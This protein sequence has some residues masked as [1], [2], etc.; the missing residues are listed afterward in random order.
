MQSYSSKGGAKMKNNLIQYKGGGYAGCYWEWNFGVF[1]RN[2]KYHDIYSS[3]KS[4]CPTERKIQR[5]IKEKEEDKDYYL[6]PLTNAKKLAEFA[7]S[8]NPDH[9]KEIIKWFIVQKKIKIN[10]KW[11]AFQAPCGFC[12]ESHHVNELTPCHPDSQGDVLIGNTD[13]ICHT[14]KTTYHSTTPGILH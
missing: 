14:C 11:D 8:S 10:I 9:V 1:D 6:Y 4:G 12:G 5:Y 2:G 13:F 7:N 3:G